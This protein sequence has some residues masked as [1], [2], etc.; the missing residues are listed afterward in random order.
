MELKTKAD[1]ARELSH[2]KLKLN[3]LFFSL[4]FSVFFFSVVILFAIS[5]A[6]Q[7]IK[8]TITKTEIQKYLTH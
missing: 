2:I 7:D 5:A 4:L 6:R 1:L 8:Q 3:I